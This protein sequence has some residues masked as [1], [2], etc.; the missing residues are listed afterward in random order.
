MGQ[1]MTDH[2]CDQFELRGVP[3]GNCDEDGPRLILVQAAT[4]HLVE[5]DF[6]HRGQ[7]RPDPARLDPAGR[8]QTDLQNLLSARAASREP[9][10]PAIYRTATHKMRTD[11][12]V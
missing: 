4:P 8:L 6:T 11:R 9:A 5:H 2:C 1:A 10:P 3:A 7:L 12:H